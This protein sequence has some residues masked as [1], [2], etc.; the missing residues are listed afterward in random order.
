MTADSMETYKNTPPKV[1]AEVKTK[2]RFWRDGAL[3]LALI[4]GPI[5]LLGLY[6]HRMVAGL[7]SPDAMDFAQLGRNLLNGHGFSTQILR[8]LALT[9]GNNPLSQ[10]E[11]THGPLYPFVLA[12]AFGVLGIK[13]SVVLGISGLFFVL[14]VPLLYLLGERLFHRRIGILAALIFM[15][16]GTVLGYAA[17]GSATMFYTFIGLGLFLSL[18]EVAIAAAKGKQ[19]RGGLLLSGILCGL[20][21]LSDPIFLCVFPVVLLGLALMYPKQWALAIATFAV[22]FGVLVLPTMIRNGMLSGNPFLGLRGSELWMGTASLPRMEG[23]RLTPTDL[24]TGPEMFL[25]V[26][27]KIFLNMAAL[28]NLLQQL[29]ASWILLAAIPGLFYRYNQ[30]GVQ[31]VRQL[32]IGSLLSVLG[33]TVLLHLNPTLLMIAVPALLVFALGY[34]LHIAAQAQLAQSARTFAGILVGCALLL[35]LLGDVVS[36]RVPASVPEAATARWL[37]QTANVGDVCISDQPWIVAW[38]ADRPAV[39][40]PRQDIQITEVR[41]QFA[42]VRWLFL[43]AQVQQLSP[44]WNMIFRDMMQWN[45]TFVQA[46]QNQTSSPPPLRI[47]GAGRPDVHLLRALDGF[48]S[49]PPPESKM[50]TA[51][52]AELEVAD[53]RAAAPVSSR[54]PDR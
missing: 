30:S 7:V 47:S 4:L 17:S 35:P 6:S 51:M 5:L 52:V 43:T 22:P 2:K 27:R 9:H 24:P 15:A 11:L 23:Y 49:A 21:Y 29:P 40:T 42:G 20:L 45:M 16:D 14:S 12:L 10:P 13:D 26:G 48:A 41:K 44:E 28:V 53:L 18:H 50:P 32:V 38:Y 25:G 39:W 34:L 46:A 31:R 8:P 19:K 36:V 3:I 33:G 37:G 54:L 1:D